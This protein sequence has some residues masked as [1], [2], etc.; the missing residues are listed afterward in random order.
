MGYRSSP[1]LVRSTWKRR[2]AGARLTDSLDREV[3]CRADGNGVA[4]AQVALIHKDGVQKRAQVAMIRFQRAA[5]R[6]GYGWEL[7]ARGARDQRAR[8]TP[9]HTGVMPVVL[10]WS[11]YLG[12]FWTWP[13]LMFT[14]DSWRGMTS[15][16]VAGWI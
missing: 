13:L 9:T 2:R 6:L 15:F 7:R 5:V 3:P 12:S 1:N 14:P 8:I 10:L 11:G 4:G 16:V